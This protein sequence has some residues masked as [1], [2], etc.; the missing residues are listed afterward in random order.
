M[1]ALDTPRLQHLGTIHNHAHYRLAS[2]EQLLVWTPA[3]A[4]GPLPLLIYLHGASS[5]GDDVLQIFDKGPDCPPGLLRANQLAPSTVVVSPLLASKR[6][7]CRTAKEAATTLATLDAYFAEATR[8]VLPT[9]DRRRVYLTG[10]SCGGLGAYTLAVR[11]ARRGATDRDHC[12][13]VAAVV[14]VCGGGNVVFAPLLASTPCWFWHAESDSAVPCA[15][16]VALVAALEK[17]DAPVRFTKLSD[18]ETPPSPAYV[19]YMTHHNA[20]APA[21]RPGSPL[22]PWLWAQALPQYDLC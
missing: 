21:Y 20:W 17:L 11:L 13:P 15:D 8:G 9:I 7:W 22:W 12:P 16:T 10:P 2:G 14:P 19:A 18:A 4:T 3:D 6:E 5:R 1:A